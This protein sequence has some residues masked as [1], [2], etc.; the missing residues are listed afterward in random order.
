MP[1]PSNNI[2]AGVKISLEL[3]SLG[4]NKALYENEKLYLNPV[5]KNTENLTSI[6]EYLEEKLNE[7][8]N[9][10]ALNIVNQ[11]LINN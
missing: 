7:T 5:C 8:L 9:E 6:K 10:I 2:R 4:H 11:F 1:I 3:I